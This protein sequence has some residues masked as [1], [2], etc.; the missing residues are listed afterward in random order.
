M[1]TDQD[2]SREWHVC[3]F[4]QH[5]NVGARSPQVSVDVSSI[6]YKYLL[7]HCIDGRVL[8]PATG[9]L[10][11]A[12]DS[13]AQRLGHHSAHDVSVEFRDVKLHRAT[14]LSKSA[15]TTFHT[16]I[17]Q[18]TNEFAVVEGDGVCASG[19]VRVLH[20]PRKCQ[21]LNIVDHADEQ[22]TPCLVLDGKDVYKELRVR[23][24]DYGPSFQ[25]ELWLLNRLIVTEICHRHC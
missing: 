23:G 11:L 9:Y 18:F 22:A 7:G 19:F 13:L 4:P 10:W 12:W 14:I 15:A 20:E 3:K 1:L 6:K 8:F 5:F 16:H 17:N 21:L 25:G 2:H 24:Y